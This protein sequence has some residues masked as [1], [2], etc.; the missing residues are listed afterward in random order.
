MYN[1]YYTGHR[2]IIKCMKSIVPTPFCF[3]MFFKFHVKI[4]ILLIYLNFNVY[5]RKLKMVGL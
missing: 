5:N 2:Y 1:I 4:K 3:L